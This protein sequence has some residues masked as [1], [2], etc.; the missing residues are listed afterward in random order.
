LNIFLPTY[1]SIVAFHFDP[2]TAA[3]RAYYIHPC[4]YDRYPVQPASRKHLL[5][6]LGDI[7]VFCGALD[8]RYSLS[9][10]CMA[11]HFP[12]CTIHGSTPNQCVL[13]PLGL[14]YDHHE[15]VFPYIRLNSQSCHP[16]SS[17]PCIKAIH[18]FGCP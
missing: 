11:I 5:K 13:S 2:S 8:H 7:L 17:V 14:A 18:R 6:T 15:L 10:K 3:S 12:L 16:F 4:F 9:D 1:L